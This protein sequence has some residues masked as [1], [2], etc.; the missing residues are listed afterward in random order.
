MSLFRAQFRR[1]LRL[2]SSSA[3]LLFFLPAISS[4]QSTPPPDSSAAPA[5]AT[6]T[7]QSATPAITTTVDEVSLDLIVRTKSNKP[8]LDLKNSDFAITDN[9]APVNL[10]NLH[11][12][13]GE[14]QSDHLVTLVFD[15][16]DPA[17]A[18]TARDLAAKIL[19]VIPDKGYYFAILQMN[20]R[21]RL[22]QPYTASRDLIDKAVATATSPATGTEAGLSSAEKDLIA[23][24][25]GDSLSVDSAER[26][27]AR[28][29]VSGLEESQRI[30]EEQH[31]YPSLSALLAIARTQRQI[32]GRKFVIYFTQGFNANSDSRDAVKSIV[33]QANRSGVT[34]CAVDS[35]PFNQQVSDR[36]QG[37]M[38]LGSVGGGGVGGAMGSA[39]S[40]ATNGYARGASGPPIGQVLDA[41]QNMSSMQFDSMDEYKSPLINLADGTG[42][43]FIK[44]GR[45]IKRPLQQLHDDLTSYYEASYTPNIK[46]YDGQFRPIAIQPIRKKLDPQK[47]RRPHPRWLLRHSSGERLRPPPL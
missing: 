26:A 3:L 45:D 31:A 30:L 18:K 17:P 1:A 35:D 15:H 20:G 4:A 6:G 9:G 39:N 41:A 27:R 46:A 33:G 7:S 38:A 43:I 25:Q 12:V 32:T 29:L 44:P 5:A 36:M 24:A 10:S 40:L 21:L 28:L 22:V 47:P 23:E 16:L 14:G 42:G 34:I 8:I 2:R 37:A 11:L 13:S 19:K